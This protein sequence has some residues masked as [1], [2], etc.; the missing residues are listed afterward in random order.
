M[1]PRVALSERPQ[2]PKPETAGPAASQE[3]FIK[4]RAIPVFP[5]LHLRLSA[6]W[7]GGL[8]SARPMCENRSNGTSLLGHIC[9]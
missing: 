8:G 6:R 2:T 9:S 3:A 4:L 1:S 5:D 7:L